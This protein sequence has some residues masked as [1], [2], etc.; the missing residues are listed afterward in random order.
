MYSAE[1]IGISFQLI[2]GHSAML[3]LGVCKSLRQASYTGDTT[4]QG[5]YL[6]HPRDGDFL[7]VS[8][9]ARKQK[10]R[11]RFSRFGRGVGG[12]QGIVL[13]ACAKLHAWQS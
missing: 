2:L 11:P 12:I 10:P 9:L 7:F 1:F 13:I 5:S 3:G 6:E 4:R 8:S